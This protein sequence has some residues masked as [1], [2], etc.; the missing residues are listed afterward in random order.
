MCM[1]MDGAFCVFESVSF[2]PCPL[3]KLP[4]AFGFTASKTWYIHYFNTEE[5]LC[6]IGPIPDVS[7]YSVNEM[8]EE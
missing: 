7:Y 2:L 5:N 6:C 1:K 3:R 4:E 8:G